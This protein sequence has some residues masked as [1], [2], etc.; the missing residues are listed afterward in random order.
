M[1]K[2]ITEVEFKLTDEIT[3]KASGVFTPYDPGVRYHRDGSGEPPSPA[4]FEIEK[5]ECNDIEKLLDH[6][7]TFYY[8]KKK[9][10]NK[11]V[12]EL[13]DK[14]FNS[15]NLSPTEEYKKK[16]EEFKRKVE[17]TIMYTD[18]DTFYEFLDEK[19]ADNYQQIYDDRLA[20]EERLIDEAT[21]L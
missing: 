1:K 16:F 20:E 11:R 15:D 6:I 4:E 13:L 3:I 2:N 10:A 14:W 21:N 17:Q 12:V 5:I 18:S 8:N 19:A 7:D 9:D